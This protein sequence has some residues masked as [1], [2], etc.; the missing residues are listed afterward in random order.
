VPADFEYDQRPGFE[1]Y[2]TEASYDEK[3]GLMALQMCI[4]VKD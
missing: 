2:P 4:A 1:R 3:T